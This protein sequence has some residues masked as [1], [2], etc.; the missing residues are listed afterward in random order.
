MVSSRSDQTSAARN[1]LEALSQQF[2][3]RHHDDWLA[4]LIRGPDSPAW[5]EGSREL[6]AAF[7]AD[8]AGNIGDMVSHAA[9]SVSLFQLGWK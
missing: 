9:K 6:A 5:A 2:R 3:Q 8:A 4:D 7:R 1:A